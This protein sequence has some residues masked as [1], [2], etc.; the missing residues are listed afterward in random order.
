M[1]IVK[2]KLAPKEVRVALNILD[3][4]GLEF[5]CEGFRMTK[6]VV[7]E[8]LLRDCNAIVSSTKEGISPRRIVYA[9]IANVAGDYLESG[10]FHMYRGILNTLG[11]GP[12]L[13]RLFNFAVDKL[14]Q[15]GD[16]PASEAEL[17]KSELQERI[18]S[19]G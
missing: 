14:V 18:Q 7:E 13:M 16:L 4:I 11:P 3:E 1:K 5:D 6:V 12:D 10:E 15:N 8:Y 19:V 2:K 9:A 17:R